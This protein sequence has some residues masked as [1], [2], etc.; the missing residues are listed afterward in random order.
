M[1]VLH[2]PRLS[3][4]HAP[5]HGALQGSCCPWQAVVTRWVGALAGTR[6]GRGR[7]QVSSGAEYLG[8]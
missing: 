4:P 6:P 2:D 5:G 3:G 7:L 1:S 8:A